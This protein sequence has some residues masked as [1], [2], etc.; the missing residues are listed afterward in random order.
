MSQ[1]LIDNFKFLPDVLIN[2]II[3]YTDVVTFRNGKYI[4]KIS[5]NDNIYKIL[6]TIPRPIKVGN[7]KVLLKLIN[8]SIHEPHGYFI[9]YIFDNYIKITIKFVIKTTDGFDRFFIE[10]SRLNLIYDVNNNWS[11]II[12]YN[13]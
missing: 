3:N 1:I 10:K 4:D 8:Y 9:E 6:E 2:K 11:T 7:K 5:K 12:D 13:I